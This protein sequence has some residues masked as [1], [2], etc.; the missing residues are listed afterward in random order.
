MFFSACAGPNGESGQST[1]PTANITSPTTNT[2]L[3]VGDEILITFS[4][5]DVKGINQIELTVDGQPVMV[6]AVE[7]SVNSYTASHR[8]KAETAGSH[9]IELRAFNINNESSDPVQAFVLVTD[10]VTETEATATATVEALPTPTVVMNTPVY[11]PAPTPTYTPETVVTESTSDET[12]IVTAVVR[13]NVRLGPSTDYPVLGQLNLNNT[14]QITGRDESSTWWQIEF[15]SDRGDR[16]WVAAGS[17]FSTASGN[18]EGVPVAEGPPL[19]VV[20]TATPT[21]PPPSPTPEPQALKP[22]IFSFTANRYTI[23]PGESVVLNWDLANAQVAYLRYDDVEEGVAAPGSKTVTPDKETKYTLVARNQVGETVAEIVI[24]VTDSGA[25]PVPVFREGKIV[26][27]NTQFIDFDQGLVQTV[28]DA[29]TD[30]QWDGQGKRFIPL[31][32]ASGALLGSSYP[33]IALNNCQAASYNQP[34]AGVDGSTL[35][36]GCFI[37]NEGRYGKFFISEWSIALN[38]TIDWLTWD[39]P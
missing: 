30:F 28:A 31:N 21:S 9:V 22:T 6:E 23:K 39:F 37:T 10:V 32:G 7:P 11:P 13:L 4:A 24:T 3:K 34:I 17:E 36:T 29:G 16:G 35:V 5:A 14:A 20:P 19:E 12:P 8:W 15:Q 1:K 2:N 27:V 25:T 18:T 38:L 33:E 26:V